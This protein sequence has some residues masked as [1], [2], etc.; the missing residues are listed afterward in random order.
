MRDYQRSWKIVRRARATNHWIPPE[1]V[2]DLGKV[3]GRTE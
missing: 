3:S 2:A 1:L